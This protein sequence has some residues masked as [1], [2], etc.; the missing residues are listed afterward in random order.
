MSVCDF[1]LLDVTKHKPF[2]IDDSLGDLINLRAL[3]VWD[4]EVLL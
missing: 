2:I 4:E 1:T 3:I